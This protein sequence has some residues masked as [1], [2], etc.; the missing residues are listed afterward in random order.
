MYYRNL[1][2]PD[3]VKELSLVISGGFTDDGQ[4]VEVANLVPG[5]P[6][7]AEYYFT[8]GLGLARLNR[9]GEALQIAQTILSRVPADELAVDNANEII[10]RCQ[11]NLIQTPIP[12]E[13][14]TGT[15]S[16]P[17]ETATPAP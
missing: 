10:N 8:Y 11:Q 1:Y 2:W 6:R 9:C 15:E 12:L 5:N 4:Q 7:I 13:T 16:V 17:A 3:S 14:P